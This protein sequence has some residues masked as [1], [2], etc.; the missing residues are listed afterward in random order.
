MSALRADGARRAQN[1]PKRTHANIYSFN[2]IQYGALPQTP[3]F[4]DVRHV[5]GEQVI[6]LRLLLCSP[7]NSVGSLP[8]CKVQALRVRFAQT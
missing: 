2:F 3:P 7:S 8:S 1:V 4:G 6:R 5:A